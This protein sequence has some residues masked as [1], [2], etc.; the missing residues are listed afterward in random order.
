MGSTIGLNAK[1]TRKNCFDSMD[2]EKRAESIAS[3]AMKEGKD[4][5]LVTTTRVTHA[6]PAGIY[7][8]TSYRHW[9]NNFEVDD[10]GCDSDYNEDVTEQLVH[11]E[12][13]KKLKV[14]FGCGSRHFLNETSSEH[15]GRG[16]RTDGKN[17]IE[18]W[19]EMKAT[20]TYVNNRDDL[21]KLN[22]LDIDQVL[23]LFDNSHCTYNLLVQRDGLQNDKPSLKDMT[24]KAIDILS[25]ND[26]GFF[27]F[28][29]GGRIDH[30]HHETRAKFALDETAEFSKAIEAALSKVNIEETL[31]IVT[32]DHSHAMTYA[33]YAVSFIPSL[34]L[35]LIKFS[36]ASWQRHFWHSWNG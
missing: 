17:L 23:G 9:E 31:I 33:G 11:G 13:G 28:V 6:S 14:V 8:H 7:A 21:M 18:E 25:Q 2:E 4:A 30:G 26:K 3:W 20:R 22:P 19:K 34:K 24:E 35:V 10:D 16:Y 15:G 1:A 36:T 12:V 29:E 32:A 27:L 5:G